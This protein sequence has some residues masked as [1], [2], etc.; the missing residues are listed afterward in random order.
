PFFPLEDQLKATTTRAKKTRQPLTPEE[1]W[2]YYSRLF[3][4]SRKGRPDLLRRLAAQGWLKGV[5]PSSDEHD[6]YL[7]GL[8][9]HAK[10]LFF[11]NGCAGS[12]PG[13][14]R[15]A[16]ASE[17][18]GRNGE[19]LNEPPLGAS[20]QKGGASEMAFRARKFCFE[21]WTELIVHGRTEPDAAVWLGDKR[22][23]LRPDGTFTLR[24]ALGEQNIPLRFTAQSADAVERRAIDTAVERYSTIRK[25]SFVPAN[26]IPPVKPPG[27]QESREEHERRL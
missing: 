14:Q 5:L 4:R 6:Y 1:I 23:D 24:Y 20:E 12:S 25:T 13:A 10:S 27:R 7:K 26:R 17:Q 22:V 15:P 9:P 21:V 19:D 8:S 2:A 3:P 16:G 11:K 18:Y